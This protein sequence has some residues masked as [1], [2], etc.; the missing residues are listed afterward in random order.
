MLQ[1]RIVPWTSYEE[2]EQVYHW[3]FP[4]DRKAQPN[5]VQRGIDRV[6]LGSNNDK[7]LQR[8]NIVI[9]LGSNMD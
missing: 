9:T 5:D 1:T 6:S 8:A 3:L 4:K 7:I 2:F